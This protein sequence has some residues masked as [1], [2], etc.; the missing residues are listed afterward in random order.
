MMYKLAYKNSIYD[1]IN[2][3]CDEHI[4]TKNNADF[5]DLI[6]GFLGENNQQGLR[7][8]VNIGLAE[9]VTEPS[10]SLLKQRY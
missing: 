5:A 4:A 8:R 9:I 10:L 1:A 7:G 6:F 2:H 3:T